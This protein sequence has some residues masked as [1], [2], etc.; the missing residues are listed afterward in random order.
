M[1][2][3]PLYVHTIPIIS[4]RQLIAQYG[5]KSQL[6]FVCMCVSVMLRNTILHKGKMEEDSESE[7][8]KQV[9]STRH[10]TTLRKRRKREHTQR[11]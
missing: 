8:D 1:H 2:T 11:L 9:V 5:V 7:T 3:Q 4:A 6:E 10:L